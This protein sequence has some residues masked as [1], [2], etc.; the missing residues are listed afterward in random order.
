MPSLTT[1]VLPNAFD[2]KDDITVVGGTCLITLS[3]LDIG[4]LVN[5]VN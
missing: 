2:S 4:A 1:V 3:L 5:Y